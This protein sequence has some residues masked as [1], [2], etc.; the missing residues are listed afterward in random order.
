MKDT[1]W[2]AGIQTVNKVAHNMETEGYARD[3][4]RPASLLNT[5]AERMAEV[6]NWNRDGYDIPHLWTVGKRP[7]V[8]GHGDITP[9]RRW[10]P[11]AMD[12]GFLTW[13]LARRGINMDWDPG[14]ILF[15]PVSAPII[16]REAWLVHY[17]QRVVGATVDGLYGNDTAGSVKQYQTKIGITADGQ[18][19]HGTWT[20]HMRIT[21][22]ALDKRYPLVTPTP[23]IIVEPPPGTPAIETR[24][25]ALERQV[26]A[27]HDKIRNLQANK[28]GVGHGSTHKV[29]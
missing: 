15:K 20:K 21:A 13:A 2:G 24:L 5:I 1:A 19:G 16:H 17:V 18:W 23:P 26:S 14:V 11:G 3:M 12:I 10:D 9:D 27:A 6:F 4:N 29:I 8:K 22:A 7:G 25:A 28:A